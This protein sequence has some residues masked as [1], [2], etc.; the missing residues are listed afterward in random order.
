MSEAIIEARAIE[1]SYPQPDG[2]R[3]QVVGL[4]DF[5]MSREK[6]SRCWGLGMRQVHSAAYFERASTALLGRAAV[7]MGNRWASRR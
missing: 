2:T 7:G 5:A 3:V 6:S 4:T 1:K